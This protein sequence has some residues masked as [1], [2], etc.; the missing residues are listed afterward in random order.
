MQSIL[1][2]GVVFE[3]TNRLTGPKQF[4][5]MDGFTILHR[6]VTFKSLKHPDFK[7]LIQQAHLKGIQLDLST[8]DIYISQEGTLLSFKNESE[9]LTYNRSKTVEQGKWGGDSVRSR[10]RNYFTDREI[11][12]STAPYI[13]AGFG[14]KYY[15]VNALY[16]AYTR[17]ALV[18]TDGDEVEAVRLLKSVMETHHINKNEG[19]DSVINLITLPRK[20]HRRLERKNTSKSIPF[21]VIAEIVRELR[22]SPDDELRRTLTSRRAMRELLVILGFTD[23]VVDSFTARDRQ[24]LIDIFDTST[25]GGPYDPFYDE[26]LAEILTTISYLDDYYKIKRAGK[27]TTEALEE[28]IPHA[29]QYGTHDAINLFTAL[30]DRDEVVY[31]H[32]LQLIDQAINA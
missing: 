12:L 4:K 26:D 3:A 17:Q 23:I 25:L 2:R 9:V 32:H 21:R 15:D 27:T 6:G 19:D 31:I 13:S 22:D 11:W 1:E 20:V 28:V 10:K 29:R 24:D 18:I 7:Y 30:M 5:V 14:H 16:D 8:D